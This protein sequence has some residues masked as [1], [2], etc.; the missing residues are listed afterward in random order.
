MDTKPVVDLSGLDL[1]RKEF[2]RKHFFSLEA[3][4]PISVLDQGSILQNSVSAEKFFKKL[5]LDT[6]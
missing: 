1:M 5:P 4:S 2:S 6:G 3:R